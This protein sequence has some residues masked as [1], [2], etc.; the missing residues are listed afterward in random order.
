MIKQNIAEVAG[1]QAAK[2]IQA[3]IRFKIIE[4]RPIVDVV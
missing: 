3:A 4:V 1:E 2:M